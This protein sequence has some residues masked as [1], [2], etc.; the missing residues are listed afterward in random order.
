VLLINDGKHAVR[1]ADSSLRIIVDPDI[2]A[3][4]QKRQL[5]LVEVMKKRSDHQEPKTI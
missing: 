3:L 2:P 1:G 4:S 5:L